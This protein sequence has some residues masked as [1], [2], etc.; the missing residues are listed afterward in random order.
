MD[1]DDPER[2]VAWRQVVDQVR[3]HPWRDRP[4]APAL[5]VEQ[6]LRGLKIP[7]LP[8]GAE[9]RE[10]LAAIKYEDAAG[11][12]GWVVRVTSDVDD[13]EVLGVLVGYVEH[14]K[15]QAAASW[16]DGDPTRASS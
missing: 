9:P 6:V 10:L 16:D 5:P 3:A 2:V 1:P 8:D 4:P 15:Q 7:G 11:D 14:L 12:E 13:D